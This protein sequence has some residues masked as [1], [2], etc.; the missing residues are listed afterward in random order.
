MKTVKRVLLCTP[1]PL[2]GVTIH[3]RNVPT[4]QT[5]GSLLKFFHEQYHCGRLNGGFF[6][7]NHIYFYE[8]CGL[9]KVIF[10]LLFISRSLYWQWTKMILNFHLKCH[11][12]HDIYPV[13]NKTFWSPAE[14]C[15]LIFMSRY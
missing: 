6:C 4:D 3:T 15:R 9:S 14:S 10:H 5:Q 11:M 2:Y 12:A 13:C 1:L 7:I 8:N